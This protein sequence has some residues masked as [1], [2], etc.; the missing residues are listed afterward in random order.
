M[1]MENHALSDNKWQSGLRNDQIPYDIYK[2][3]LVRFDL[4]SSRGARDPLRRSLRRYL[5]AF[6][7]FVRFGRGKFPQQAH[8]DSDIDL[9]SHLKRSYWYTARLVD[10]ITR[11]L[12]ALLAGALLIIPLLIMSKQSSDEVHLVTMSLCVILLSFTMSLQSKTSNEQTVAATAG[13][14][15]VLV[16]FLSRGSGS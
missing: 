16:V 15:A 9:G 13:Y 6:W 8:L 12:V 3:R 7:F 14:A 5:R 4:A 11:F 10:G 1:T 2:T